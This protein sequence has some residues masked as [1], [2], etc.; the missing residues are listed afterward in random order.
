MSRD[1]IFFCVMLFLLLLTSTWAWWQTSAIRSFM[2]ENPGPKRTVENYA[3]AELTAPPANHPIWPSPVAQ[4]HGG[5]WIYDVFTPPV[6]YYDSHALRFS[7]APPPSEVTEPATTTGKKPAG[8]SQ[9][10]LFRLQLVGFIGGEGNY[11]GTFENGATTEHFLA[12][13]GYQVPSLGLTIVAFDVRRMTIESPDSMS[14]S[15]L[16]AIARV[17]DDLSGEEVTLTNRERRYCPASWEEDEPA[18]MPPVG[19]PLAES[20]EKK[21]APRP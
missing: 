15:E 2:A 21:S 8:K 5:D 12:R 16:V 20:G 18:R 17:H 14:T 10:E 1:K 6:I 3:P 13:A 4:S 9:R 7:V 19:F 11:A